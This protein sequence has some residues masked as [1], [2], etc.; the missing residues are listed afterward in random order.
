MK[1]CPKCNAEVAE[2]ATFCPKCGAKLDDSEIEEISP[3]TDGGVFHMSK[4]LIGIAVLVIIL[5]ILALSC[6]DKQSH[7]TALNDAMISYLNKSAEKDS[8]DESTAM[9]TAGL[10]SSIVPKVLNSKL[11]VKNYILFSI[12]EFTDEGKSETISIGVLGHVFPVGL[13]GS[14]KKLDEAINGEHK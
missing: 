3:S 6:P 10:A 14:E 4:I 5:I 13:K 12:G 11:E 1:I 2:D 8:L 7:V 9:L